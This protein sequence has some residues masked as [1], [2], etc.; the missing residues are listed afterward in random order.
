MRQFGSQGRLRQ[1]A[2]RVREV[3]PVLQ[4]LVL[5]AVIS[6]M[7]ALIAGSSGASPGV[8]ALVALEPLPLL[9]RRTHPT[10]VIAVVAVLDVA[11]LAGGATQAAVGPTGVVA[12]Y[13]AGAHQRRPRSLVSLAV[14]LVGLVGVAA[15]PAAGLTPIDVVGAG[16]V[17]TVA[18]WFGSTLRERREH[19]AELERRT[20]ALEAARLELAERAV[21]EERLRLARELHDVI[22][23]TLAIIAVHSSVGAHN[24]AAR[25]Q[26]AVVALDAVNAATRT[27]LTELRAMLA[28]LRDSADRDSADP[29]GL[30]AGPLP[31]LA[32]LAALVEQAG[33]AGL[34]VRL[35]VTGDVGSLPRAV[36]L[37]AYRIVQ[38]ALT[39]VVKH[40][41]PPVDVDVDVT[42][43]PGRV[44]LTVGNGP[45]DA[46]TGGAG[47]GRH[48]TRRPPGTRGRLRRR[49]RRGTDRRRRL[50]RPGHDDLRGVHM[51]VRVLL[52]DDQDMVRAGFRML[53]DAADRHGG[54]GR[55]DRR[56]AGGR[57]HPAAAAGRGRH[58][59]PHAQSGRH[60]GDPADRRRPGAGPHPG[61]DPDHVRRRRVRLQ[62]LA[63]GGQRLPAQGRLGGRPA[64]RD[65]RGGRR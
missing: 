61:A 28:V 43:T 18:W 36:S 12:A 37:S 6:T 11:L 21:T 34:R 33:G 46:P 30:P 38:E 53:L 49:V 65:P 8:A 60:R 58:G 63:R 19:A 20:R 41:G 15:A 64:G 48:R 54:G 2:V 26:D 50:G 45:T 13:S 24:A 59:H 5:V 62:R 39:N 25:P 9:M 42:V 29:V 22:A 17:T 56:P 35:A 44:E 14:A 27:A 23:H 16:L 31:S 32:D 52:C 47:R 40:A 55:G 3:P 10:I 1:A 51:S 57:G 7:Q 4:D